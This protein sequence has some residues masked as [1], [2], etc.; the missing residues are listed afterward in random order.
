MLNLIA[1]FAY[2]QFLDLLTT[3][4]F[5]L[6]GVREYNP[7]LNFLMRAAGTPLAGL[8]AAKAAA[9]AL[10]FYCWRGSRLTLLACANVFYALLVAWNLVAFVVKAAG[11]PPG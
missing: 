8:L 10:G 4:V 3:L 7:A 1:Q 9:L 6:G 5:L 2:L 11:S